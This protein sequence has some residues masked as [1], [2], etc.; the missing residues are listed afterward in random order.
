MTSP[1]LTDI[2][3]ELSGTD[4][5]RTYPRD[6]PDLFEGGQLVWAGRYRQSGRTTVAV[7]GKV[8]DERRRFEFPADLARP[9]AARAHDFVERIWAIRR[10]GDIIDQIDLHGRTRS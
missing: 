3:I 4:V 5:N 2:R 6:I 10:V 7:S 1:V 9:A 8:G